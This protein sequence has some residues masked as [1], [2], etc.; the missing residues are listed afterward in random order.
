MTAGE[1][2]AQ[3]LLNQRTCWKKGLYFAL[4]EGMGLQDW[5]CRRYI[6]AKVKGLSFKM[7]VDEWQTF[8]IT[9]ER[10]RFEVLI[11]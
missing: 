1:T 7:G 8:R 10:G 3:F 9:R 6:L 5:D 11:F 4:E 2:F